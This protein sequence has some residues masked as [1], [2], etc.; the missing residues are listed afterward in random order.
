MEKRARIITVT[1]VI[2]AAVLTAVLALAALFLHET[3]DVYLKV[4]PVKIKIIDEETGK[5][6]SGL[7]VYHQL[8]INVG[9]DSL[10]NGFF[11]ESPDVK[12]VRISEYMTDNSG[13]I[14]IPADLV[15]TMLHEKASL[16][17]EKF[18]VNI[19][20]IEKLNGM[21]EPEALFSM[22]FSMI[23]EKDLVRKQNSEYQSLELLC[24]SD[25]IESIKSS[26]NSQE[27]IETDGIPNS[28]D[29]DLEVITV[30]LK[31]AM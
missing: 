16:K 13:E 24:A 15:K 10:W 12:S 14:E 1:A 25:E 23:Y 11:Q 8:E 19:D 31:R 18:L 7:K 22:P 5:P 3:R 2:F 9:D 30:N 21:T 27:W 6:V 28:F 4:R 29:K 17:Y 26:D 20:P